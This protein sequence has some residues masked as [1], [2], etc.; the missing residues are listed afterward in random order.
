M[1]PAVTYKER[2]PDPKPKKPTKAAEPGAMKEIAAEHLLSEGITELPPPPAAAAA[3]APK[4]LSDVEK[5]LSGKAMASFALRAIELV[6]SFLNPDVS[7]RL[8]QKHDSTL[9]RVQ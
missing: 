6:A 4:K 1:D 5:A 9:E 7:R 3:G 2:M 8:A